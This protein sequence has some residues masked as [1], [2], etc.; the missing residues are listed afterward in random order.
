[1]KNRNIY[2]VRVRY[3]QQNKHTNRMK[4]TLH[5]CIRSIARLSKGLTF[6]VLVLVPAVAYPQSVYFGSQEVYIGN[7]VSIPGDVVNAGSVTIGNGALQFYGNEY[8]NEATASYNGTGYVVFNAPGSGTQSLFGGNISFRNLR[9]SNANNVN[10]AGAYDVGITDTLELAS[11]RLILGGL[12]LSMGSNARFKGW[13]MDRYV[14]TNGT[15]VVR[16]NTVAAGTACFF[17]IGNST[18]TDYSPAQVTNGS[19]VQTINLRVQRVPGAGQT[20][21]TAKGVRRVWN[22]WTNNGG[23]LNALML[24]HH[25]S[26]SGS[27]YDA[28][29]ASVIRF[30]SP[31]W[32]SGPC[33]F[34][35]DGLAGNG[36]LALSAHTTLL[37]NTST[38][39]TGNAYYSKTSDLVLPA[40]TP[41]TITPVCQ[42]T[43]AASLPYT[44][45]SGGVNQYR[46]SWGAAASTAGFA[47][48]SNSAL[49]A[50]PISIPVPANV[51]AGSYNGTLIVRNS[52]NNCEQSYPITVEVLA[53]PALT[54]G[55]IAAVCQGAT[56][57][58]L[59]YTGATG[60][61]NQYRI[62]WDG[63]A[64]IAGFVNVPNTTLPASPISVP[65]PAGVA[66]ATYNATLT[67]RNSTTG[68]ERNY[69][70]NVQVLTKPALTP[71]SI[72]PVCQ[73]ATTASLPYTGA[74]GGA[75]QYSITWS[76]AAQTAGFSNVG[77]TT[78]PASPISIPVPAGVAAGTY[79]A[80][81][82]V[83]N[84]STT[85]DA[86]YP[87]SVE[88]LALPA[89]TP[90]TIAA[91][92]QGATTAL[93]P[94]TG[95]TGGA[96]QY[97]ITW[98]GAAQTAGFSNV[99]LTTLS[100][101]PISIPVPA[102]VAAGTYSAT[103]TVRNSS[104]T[105]E[106]T[107]SISVQVLATPSLTPGT[108]AAVC[109]GSSIASL[110]YTGAAGGVNQY[111]IT[112]DATAQAAGFAPVLQTTLPASPITV[113]VSTTAPPG[114]YN[115]V[116]T[117][118]NSVT[119][120][121]RSY[122][123]SAGI[124]VLPTIT[125]GNNPEI[126]AGDTEAELPYTATTH[127]PDRYHITW[128]AGAITAGFTNVTSA[129][130]SASAGTL[131]LTVPGTAAAGN[132]SGILTVGNGDCGSIGYNFEVIVHPVP[133]AVVTPAGPIEIC[134]GD[135]VQLDAGAPQAGYTY[136]WRSG[137]TPVGSN[138]PTYMADTTGDYTVIVDNGHCADT[139]LIVSV[140][141]HP[142][143]DVTITPGDTAF[144]EGGKV[145]LQV[146]NGV[147][148]AYQWKRDGAPVSGAQAFFLEADQTGVYTV[149][150]ERTNVFSCKD[151]SAPVAVTVYPLPQPVVSWDGAT[152]RTDSVYAGYEWYINGQKIAGATSFTYV[153][154]LDGRYSV[155][156]T[157]SNGCTNTSASVLADRVGIYTMPAAVSA[158]RIY[159][160]PSTGL[161]FV[162]SAVPV[163]VSVNSID[164]KALLRV[165]EAK[166][167]DI[168]DLPGG[169]YM[170]YV[171]D[172]QGM[173]L[174]VEKLTK[175]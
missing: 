100:S 112:W 34:S 92:C 157:D 146:P 106:Q 153:P 131:T 135:S 171:T 15:G 163:S 88:V 22:L 84:S 45:P 55:G 110:P 6:T 48:V 13:N 89:I 28:I 11:G 40:L 87:I 49:P 91:V 99:G 127:N 109:Q 173:I 39:A 36:L 149:V 77:L 132:Y 111:S 172:A 145:I 85:C 43:T 73:G 148:Q 61:V 50:S 169:V 14:V 140:T 79:L 42:G 57:A 4:N 26:L 125:L 105:C 126:C 122:P 59:P 3:Q 8:R 141:W 139:S 137:T 10:L 24:Y 120:C 166:Q 174:K 69:S 150:V 70:I 158:V 33:P 107:Y 155:T 5:N 1:V 98:S 164:G 52:A 161:V 114:T 47:P 152:L 31:S 51:A 37:T 168:S 82:T 71:G 19:T 32:Q 58:S 134:F 170:I 17:P 117:V 95:A 142:R 9:I 130:L 46:I 44:G 159:P 64:T 16:Y 68:C 2:P 66:A 124:T 23:G 154:L 156:V 144:C 62:T 160:N 38:T 103:L 12:N 86:T 118:R 90:G 67:V 81:L 41:G 63:T 56:T 162:E 165:K 96:N 151:S 25:D 20:P 175:N 60:G 108:I 116:L 147:S 97:S 133:P 143:P 54:P 83:R 94:Y 35:I 129:P 30:V 18:G 72:T 80:T 101:S 78:L 167:V 93:L 74:T 121:E 113:P 104:T 138:S 119:G 29:Q 115:G 102:G 75:N 128:D 53:A 136:L 76:G 7:Q 65:V 123:I 21:D 27:Q